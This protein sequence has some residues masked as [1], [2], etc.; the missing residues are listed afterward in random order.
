MDASG[1]CPILCR[2]IDGLAMLLCLIDPLASYGIYDIE[3]SQFVSSWRLLEVSVDL[4][5][6]YRFGLQQKVLIS[7]C[8]TVWRWNMVS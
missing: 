2:A 3:H 4:L 5:N 7:M 1:V 8:T 6:E